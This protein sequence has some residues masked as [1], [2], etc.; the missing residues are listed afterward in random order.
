M[1]V[2]HASHEKEWPPCETPKLWIGMTTLWDIQVM[3][4][5]DH[6]VGHQFMSRNDH[7]V[8]HQVMIRNDHHEK[9]WPPC[10]TPKSLTGVITTIPQ[11]SSIWVAWQCFVLSK[12]SCFIWF[13]CKLTKAIA[14]TQTWPGIPP[15]LLCFR[16]LWT[17]ADPELVMAFGV[18]YWSF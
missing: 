18:L 9:E 3:S 4:R 15:F 1:P 6:P 8:R 17:A 10:E 2:R 16:T 12:H 14:F 13:C 7:S 11:S 5:N